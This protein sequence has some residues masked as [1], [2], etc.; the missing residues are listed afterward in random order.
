MSASQPRTTTHALPLLVLA[1]TV[2]VSGCSR[3]GS[4]AST[5]ETSASA[6]ADAAGLIDRWIESVGGMEPHWNLRT[7]TFTLTTEMWDAESGRLRR[8]RPRYVWIARTEEGLHSRV[9][10]W[11]GDDF[12]AHGWNPQGQWAAMNGEDLSEGDKDWDEADYVGGDV[13]YWIGLPWKL[14]DPGVNL[15]DAGTDEDGRRV[16]R[17]TFGEGVGDHQDTWHY[18]FRDAEPWPVQVDY[19]EAGRTNTNHTRWEDIQQTDGYFHVGRRVHFNEE[20]QVTKVI[21]TS[22]LRVNPDLDL[23]LFRGP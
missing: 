4:A 10:R 7:A 19:Q 17:V 15:E 23:A 1:A 21:R 16:V 11:E 14:K 22:D 13:Q 6:P 5:A 3:A 20:G 8:T 9:E 2:L 12:I 18:Y